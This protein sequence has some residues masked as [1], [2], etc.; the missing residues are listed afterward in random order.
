MHQ[1]KIKIIK[2]YNHMAT[3]L[4][5]TPYFPKSQHLVEWFWRKKSIKADATSNCFETGGFGHK[6]SAWGGHDNDS[7]DSTWSPFVS[8][9][10]PLLSPQPNGS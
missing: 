10:E 2:L 1:N 4:R 7:T 5:F 3:L 8:P 6:L 9:G